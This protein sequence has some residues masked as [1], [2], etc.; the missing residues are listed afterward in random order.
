M[1]TV[2]H[3]PVRVVVESEWRPRTPIE[4]QIHYL[5]VDT[6]VVVVGEKFP[7]PRELTLWCGRRE[8]NPGQCLIRWSDEPLDE[9]GNPRPHHN[10]ILGTFPVHRLRRVLSGS[11]VLFEFE[12]KWV[13]GKVCQWDDTDAR[14]REERKAKE[15]ERSKEKKRT[16]RYLKQ[17][18]AWD[19][20]N[21]GD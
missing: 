2:K 4:S 15:R 13:Q 17:P 3:I 5:P 10:K 19:R 12:G 6:R 16:N 11:R 8:S 21:S 7:D 14:E 9:E 20:I 18:T 1:A